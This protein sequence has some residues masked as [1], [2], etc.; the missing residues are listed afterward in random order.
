MNLKV[1]D[2][3][4]ARLAN[5]VVSSGNELES[6]ASEY[7]HLIDRLNEEGIRSARF[8]DATRRLGPTVW[9]AVNKLNEAT[10]TLVVQTNHYIEQLNDADADFD[11]EV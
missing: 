10:A 4:F 2:P 3:E 9:R 5:A 6:I 11:T 8:L 7:A 1:S